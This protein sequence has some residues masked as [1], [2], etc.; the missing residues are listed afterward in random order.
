M[1]N[2]LLLFLLLQTPTVAVHEA[3]LTP[4][5]PG[6]DFG[7]AL[8]LEG[9][10]LIAGSTFEDQRAG[11]VYVYERSGSS[12][13]G[14]ERLVASDGVAFDRFGGAVAIDGEQLIVGSRDSA[15][16][17]E[18]TL[19]GWIECAKLVGSD[20]GPDDDFGQRVAIA[21]D[22]AAVGAPSAPLSIFEDVGAVYLFQRSGTDWVQRDRIVASDGG[23]QGAFGAT[24]EFEGDRIAVG[25]GSPGVPGVYVFERSGTAW[26]EQT[27]ITSPNGASDFSFGSV[28][29]FDGDLIAS[30]G[31]V[32]FSANG[33]RI[34][35]YREVNGSWVFEES[36]RAH[37]V[38]SGGGFFGGA[39]A[40]QG[41][42][43]FVASHNPSRVFAFE[44]AGATWEQTG[45]SHPA[46]PQD[47]WGNA[48][49][50]D[51][52]RAL[53]N[54][55]TSSVALLTVL[56]FEQTQHPNFCAGNGNGCTACPCG[57]D[58]DSL[59]FGGCLNGEGSSAALVAT[60]AASVAND[61]LR[62]DLTGALANGF[63]L[64]VSAVDPL[65]LNGPCP[66]GS[67][68]APPVF[69]G[70]RCIGNG[71]IRHGTR[72]VDE[73]GRS[74]P[75][76][77]SAM[78]G[79]VAQASLAVGDTRHFQVFYRDDVSGGCGTGANTSNAITVTAV[80]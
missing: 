55:P 51:G 60:G 5:A 35:L 4:N 1:S 58:G 6:I 31:R 43:L 49:A 63:A 21:G 30:A 28:R 25:G 50:I 56:K 48:S 44:R 76:S 37:D 40:I 61:T 26:T 78:S 65:P 45:V 16:V 7:L 14:G 22:W 68:V 57:N 27:K 41:D 9:D 77:G 33:R 47:A 75:W 12:W 80:P 10:R 36:F 72:A 42:R 62:F 46:D 11:A 52:E 15:Y 19:G 24:L 79:L 23:T 64:L 53:F 54:T 8:D 71:L 20:T 66:P 69:D 59:F 73:D 74:N 34:Y 70:L 32:D 3:T 17:F 67:G 39:A 2:G 13:D 38:G 29:F 18:N